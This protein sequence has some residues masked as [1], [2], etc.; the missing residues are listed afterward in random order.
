M[1]L[2]RKYMIHSE[3]ASYL[4]FD[5]S[6]KRINTKVFIYSQIRLFCLLVRIFIIQFVVH[7]RV[8][9]LQ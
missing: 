9:L 1:I 8:E 2:K 3:I 5:K 6:K 4:Q 7:F